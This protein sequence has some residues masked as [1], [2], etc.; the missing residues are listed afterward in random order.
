[1]T[2]RF[3]RRVSGLPVRKTNPPASAGGCSG[4]PGMGAILE[5]KVLSE[6]VHS[7]RSEAQL[8]EGDRVW[9]G[10]VERNREPMD[11]NPIQGGTD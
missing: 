6:A 7:N 9:G 10:S 4:A 8:H 2:R 5:V 3:S 1:M 11:K